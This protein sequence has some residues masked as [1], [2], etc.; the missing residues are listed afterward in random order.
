MIYKL[1]KYGLDYKEEK[2]NKQKS[3]DTTTSNTRILNKSI[4]GIELTSNPLYSKNIN[5]K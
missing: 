2:V 4:D 5:D 3:Y 1:Y